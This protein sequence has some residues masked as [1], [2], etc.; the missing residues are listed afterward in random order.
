[1]RSA[2]FATRSWKTTHSLAVF[3]LTQGF[4]FVHGL[5]HHVFAVLVDQLLFSHP[6]VF[7]VN[8]RVSAVLSSSSALSLEKIV[9]RWFS[10][11]LGRQYV[12]GGVRMMLT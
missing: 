11:R 10:G 3:C 1:M 9:P 5:V 12:G 2:D 7:N 6:G 8:H 4:Y